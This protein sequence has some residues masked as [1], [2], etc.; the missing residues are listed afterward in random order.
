MAAVDSHPEILEVFEEC[1]L[2]HLAH[3]RLCVKLKNIYDNTRF[4]VF[5]DDFLELC[6]YSL[7]SSERSLYRERTV[8]F[9]TK[10]ALFCGKDSNED[11]VLN[12]IHN[13]ILL[14]LI[15]FCI[16][17]NEC[18]NPAVRFRC[19]QI[20]HKLL[21]G[22]GDNGILPGEIY[23]KLQDVLLRRVYDVKVSVRVE[24][25]KAISRMQDPN[26]AQ[27]NV[28]EA[29]MWLTRH[30]P[31]AEV[32]RAA[33][34]A[35]VL[36]T[37]TLGHLLERCRD[38]ADNVRRTAYKIL[39]DRSIIRPLSI[40]KRIRILQDGLSDR[41]GKIYLFHSSVVCVIV[42]NINT[43]DDYCL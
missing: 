23:T 13:R 33:A 19:M 43:Y 6:R 20:I 37:R 8:D 10:F 31:T 17:Y 15:I 26:D 30:D 21:D 24:A 42:C 12:T 18:P 28:V 22:I 32:R 1:Q 2:N 9:I 38:V 29:F 27:C 16:K 39:A 25:I 40:A 36:T 41:S 4:S 5:A 35:M 34:A 11:G 3:D 14:R 7:V